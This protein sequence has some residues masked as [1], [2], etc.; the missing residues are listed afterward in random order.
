SLPEYA[1]IAGVLGV[2]RAV[3][4]A[5]AADKGAAGFLAE[6]IAVRQ[7]PLADRLLDDHSEAAGNAAEK[8]MPGIYQ[9]VRGEPLGG[10]GL[11]R[12]RDRG[13]DGGRRLERNR[14]RSHETRDQQY[15]KCCQD[16]DNDRRSR[17]TSEFHK[18]APPL[19]LLMLTALVPC[20]S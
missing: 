1:Q 16:R 7:P 10:H 17:R 13:R 3:A 9:F 2:E 6:N 18:E 8:S 15:G 12:R 14:L 5:Q 4:I 20:L 11:R 19:I